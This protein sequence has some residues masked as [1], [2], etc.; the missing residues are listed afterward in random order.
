MSRNLKLLRT[1]LDS[2][3]DA[4]NVVDVTTGRF[5][6]VNETSCRS[7]GYTRDEQLALTVFDV[8]AGLDRARYDTDIERA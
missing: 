2:S 7:L 3:D 6:D 4:I 5:L 8:A 1:L